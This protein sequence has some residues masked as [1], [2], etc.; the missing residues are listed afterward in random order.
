MNS[1]IDDL[2]RD[3]IE[4]WKRRSTDDCRDLLERLQKNELTDIISALS[5]YATHPEAETRRLVPWL[6]AD[7]NQ[8][9]AAVSA[10][11]DGLRDP[12]PWVRQNA[13]GI[14]CNFRDPAAVPALIEAIL[15]DTSAD[16]RVDACHAL[17]AIRD[18]RAIPALQWVAENDHALN[19]EDCPVSSYAE[20][21]IKLI[22]EPSGS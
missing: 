13:C 17:G 15:N 21:Y 12:E 1:S 22:Q 8:Q 2:I 4:R 9:A 5:P 18:G 3:C 20:A 7:L 10:A 19:W 11:I 6:L 16:V 14:L